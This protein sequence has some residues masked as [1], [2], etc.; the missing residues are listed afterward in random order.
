[1]GQTYWTYCNSSLALPGDD[2]LVVA[3]L[4]GV[5]VDGGEPLLDAGEVHQGNRA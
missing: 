5:L 2:V 1:M 3:E 4:A